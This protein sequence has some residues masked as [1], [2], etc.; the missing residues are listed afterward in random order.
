MIG[1]LGWEIDPDGT[2]SFDQC[3]AQA[4]VASTHITFFVGEGEKSGPAQP[5]P[6]QGRLSVGRSPRLWFP[7]MRAK[8]WIPGTCPLQ[9][10]IIVLAIDA[11]RQQAASASPAQW[12]PLA[13]TTQVCPVPR[14]STPSISYPSKLARG[15]ASTPFRNHPPQQGTKDSKNLPIQ[16]IILVSFE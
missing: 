4:L 1:V 9:N 6:P 3:S 2:K 10:A 5:C 16:T 11:P 15:R 14:S 12:R 13:H 8:D 7:G